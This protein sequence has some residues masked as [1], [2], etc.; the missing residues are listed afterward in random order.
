MFSKTKFKSL[1]LAAA[2]ALMLGSAP[3]NARDAVIHIGTEATFAPFAFF[4]DKAKEMAGFDID[5]IKAIMDEQGL[6]YEISSMS[7]DSLIPS[8]LSGE[9]DVS[10]AGI[11]ITEARAKRVAVSAP[12]YK[13]GLGVMVNVNLKNPV[14]SVEDLKGRTICCQI[15]TSA[16]LYASELE[17][18]RVRQFNTANEANF[19]LSHGVC[20]ASVNDRLMLEYYL[21]VTKDKNLTV[22]PQF[23]TKEDYGIVVD[24]GNEQLLN[25]INEGLEKIRANGT[26][27]KIYAKWFGHASK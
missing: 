24:R 10:V 25:T 13:S 20:D 11:T 17:G 7:F 9:I 4:D 3:A 26:Y 12:Y 14:K 15:G 27:D 22:L 8:I 18:T 19:E 2:C 6:K 5:L 23:I 21:T 1:A 16:V